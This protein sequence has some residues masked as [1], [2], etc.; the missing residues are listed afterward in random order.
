M[1]YHMKN[2]FR[3]TMFWISVAVPLITEILKIPGMAGSETV[4]YIY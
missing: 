3:D 1:L 2:T 4:I